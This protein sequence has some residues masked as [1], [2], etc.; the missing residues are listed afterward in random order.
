MSRVLVIALDGYESTIADALM[1]SGQLPALA[2]LRDKSARF[3]LDHGSA[4][5]TGLG[6]EHVST[7]MSPQDTNRYSS[8]SFDQS[9]YE[10]WA[11]GPQFAPFPSKIRAKT[12]VFDLPYFDLLPV[13]NINVFL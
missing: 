13:T 6:A 12:V 7:G 9:S 8:V 2:Y 11:E 3:L 5:R 4:K 10:V 1:A